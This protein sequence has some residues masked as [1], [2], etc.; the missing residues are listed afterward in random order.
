M[1]GDPKPVPE[2]LSHIVSQCE[3]TMDSVIDGYNRMVLFNSVGAWL[4]YMDVTIRTADLN[5]N[6]DTASYS[7]W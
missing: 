6:L 5:P 1:G 2:V 7:Y 4:I 3:S